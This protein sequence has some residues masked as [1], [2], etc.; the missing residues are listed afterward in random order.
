MLC[1]IMLFQTSAE[2]FT[3]NILEFLSILSY[4]FFFYSVPNEI[5]HNGNN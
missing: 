2:N 3:Y 5:A 1:W 4:D